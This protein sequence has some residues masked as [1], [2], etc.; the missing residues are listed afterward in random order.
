ME[1]S[2]YLLE[3]LNDIANIQSILIGCSTLSQEY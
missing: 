2:S 3:N 1:L